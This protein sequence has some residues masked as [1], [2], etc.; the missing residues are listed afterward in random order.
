MTD[1]RRFNGEVLVEGCLRFGVSF[2]DSADQKERG[3]KAKR[4]E[5]LYRRGVPVE[6]RDR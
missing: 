3:K 4:G 2:N 6:K 5:Q 1:E